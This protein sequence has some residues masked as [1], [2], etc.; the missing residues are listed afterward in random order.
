MKDIDRKRKFLE[1]SGIDK[2][3]L[4]GWVDHNGNS[5]G[6]SWPFDQ[7]SEKRAEVER[8]YH[9]VVAKVT[10][11]PGTPLA[12][13]KGGIDLNAVHLNLQIKPDGHGVPLP[14]NRQDMEQLKNIQGF[15][16]EIIEIKPPS[17]CLSLKNYSYPWWHLLTADKRPL[18]VNK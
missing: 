11:P 8:S 2:I 7:L 17:I 3:N 13:N 12:D 10:R 18:L 16:P 4:N 14:I 6:K 5:I 9:S 15:V 1:D